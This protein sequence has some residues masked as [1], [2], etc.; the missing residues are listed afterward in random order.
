[1]N[2]TQIK[3]LAKSGAKFLVENPKIAHGVKIVGEVVKNQQDKKMVS[4]EKVEEIATDMAFLKSELGKI[5]KLMY[6]AI[7]I[8]VASLTTAIISIFC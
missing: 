3:N 1:M 2:I 6:I 7:A 4:Q 5:K 8:G